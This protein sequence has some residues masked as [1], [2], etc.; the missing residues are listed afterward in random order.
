M[1]VLRSTIFPRP[2]KGAFPVTT[3]VRDLDMTVPLE[4]VRTSAEELDRSVLVLSDLFEVPDDTDTVAATLAAERRIRKDAERNMAMLF[5]WDA[6]AMKVTNPRS[7]ISPTLPAPLGEADVRH[8]LDALA[9]HPDYRGHA[10]VAICEDWTIVAMRY[11]RIGKLGP[12]VRRLLEGAQEKIVSTKH[13]TP[14]DE[15]LMREIDLAL[16]TVG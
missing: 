2:V 11:G 13:A 9:K 14:R 1:K 6:M 12:N 3:V 16:G 5:H 10:I 4:E 15:A 7:V 8:V